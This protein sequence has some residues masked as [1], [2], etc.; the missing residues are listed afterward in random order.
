MNIKYDLSEVPEDEIRIN[1]TARNF[2]LFDLKSA[3]MEM[4]MTRLGAADPER[5]VWTI[6]SRQGFP[7]GC[8]FFSYTIIQRNFDPLTLAP[9][10]YVNGSLFTY[11]IDQ[12]CPPDVLGNHGE[13]IEF[14]VDPLVA[15]KTALASD[16]IT[17]PDTR[18]YGFFHTGLTR[19]DIG[20]LRYLYRTNNMN[21]EQSPPDSTF[22]QTNFSSPGL[23]PAPG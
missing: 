4:L 19:D 23:S 3:A 1:Y 10:K 18:F 2:K 6:R 14:P 17:F 9:S 13:A 22:F 15:T 20:C 21:V 8:P 5:W 12:H 16:K 7:P 11:I